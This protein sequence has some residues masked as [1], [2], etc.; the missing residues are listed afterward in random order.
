M[1]ETEWHSI[2]AFTHRI[3]VFGGW[4]VRYNRDDTS[5][6][7]FIPDVNHEWKI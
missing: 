5:S 6:M 2:E 7:V 1:I 3:K 4:V